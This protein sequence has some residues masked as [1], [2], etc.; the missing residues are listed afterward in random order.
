MRTRNSDR[1]RTTDHGPRTS[2]TQFAFVFALFTLTLTFT[3]AA[4]ESRKS[5]DLPAGDA[6]A[7]LLLI[8]GRRAPRNGQQQGQDGY[9]LGGIP[10]SAVERVEVLLDGASAVYGADAVGGVINVI[11]KRS[12]QS[13]DLRLSYENTLDSDANVKSASLNHGFAAGKLSGMV[14]VSYQESGN[15][16]WRDRD[17]LRTQDRR[18]FGGSN[19]PAFQIP[20]AN[21]TIRVPAGNAAGV[22]SGTVLT[23]PSGSNGSNKTPADYVAAGSSGH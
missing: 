8:N 10:L 6:V 9:D 12:Y 5:Y 17:F 14:T 4:T 20:R 16:M 18:E 7:T 21:G 2:L 23:I 11:L 13:T 22:P 1:L 3:L 19:N 15:L